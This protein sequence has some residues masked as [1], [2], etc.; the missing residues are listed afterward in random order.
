MQIFT[1]IIGAIV[2][3]IVLSAIFALP[4]MWLWNGLLPELFAFPTVTWLQA[5]GL[6]IL[7]SLLF[8]GTARASSTSS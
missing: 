2:L 6:S 3:V 7:G 5:W 4:V 8:G 1:I